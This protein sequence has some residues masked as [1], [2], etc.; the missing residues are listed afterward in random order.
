MKVRYAA[1]RFPY[2]SYADLTE[3]RLIFDQWRQQ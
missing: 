1:D 3:E 2:I